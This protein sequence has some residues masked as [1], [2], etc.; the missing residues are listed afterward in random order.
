MRRTLAVHRTTV[1]VDLA[2]SVQ[3]HPAYLVALL[4]STVVLRRS[5]WQILL[6][7]ARIASVIQD[8]LELVVP[9]LL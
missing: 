3:Y 8:V 9:A 2:M 6:V 1:I 5:S 4:G 7:S